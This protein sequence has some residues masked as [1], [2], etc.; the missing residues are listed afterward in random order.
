MKVSIGNYVNWIGPHQ[1]A[2]KLLFWKPRDSYAVAKL[3]NFLEYGLSRQGAT[4]DRKTWFDKL[5]NAVYKWRQRKVLVKIDP[6]DVWNLDNTLALIILPALRKF[7]SG[8]F[9]SPHIDL[10]DVPP[11]LRCTDFNENITQRKFDFYSN[12]D[13]SPDHARWN[14][15]LDE[16]IWAFEQLQPDCDWESAYYSGQIDYVESKTA[17]GLTELK[18]GP[19]HTSKIDT[20]GLAAHSDR[21]SRGLQLFGKYYRSLWIF[22]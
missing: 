6:W 16:M 21:I 1:I 15:V 13:T 14:W 22:I 5:C 17:N 7:K 8:R 4:N 20:V 19:N 18:H 12:S 11:H 2:S 3:S 10:E 9:G